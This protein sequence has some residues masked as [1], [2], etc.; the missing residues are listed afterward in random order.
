MAAGVVRYMVGLAPMA[1]VD[2]CAGLVGGV[3]AW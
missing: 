1:L 2:V 3:T